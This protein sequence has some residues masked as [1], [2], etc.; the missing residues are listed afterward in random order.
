[1]NVLTVGDIAKELN[2]GRD[3]VTYAVRKANIQLNMFFLHT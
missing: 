2:V 1:M 3:V